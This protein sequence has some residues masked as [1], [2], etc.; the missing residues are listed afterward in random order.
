MRRP[1]SRVGRKRR[2]RRAGRDPVAVPFAAAAMPTACAALPHRVA[3]VLRGACGEDRAVARDQPESV[4]P[5]ALACVAVRIARQSDDRT[6]RGDRR[7]RGRV[8]EVEDAA[9]GRRE[10][11]AASRLAVLAMPTTGRADA[12]AAGRAV[13]ARV[14]EREDAAVGRDEP[15]A[16]TVRASMPCRRSA[17]SGAS[18]RSSRGSARCR[19]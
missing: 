7:H 4:L 3:V 8:A 9:V 15:V 10:P 18:R 2:A 12:H 11:V 1:D 5:V 19:S 6:R 13:E 16:A 17:S 14:A